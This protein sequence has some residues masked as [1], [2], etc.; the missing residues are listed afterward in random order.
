MPR[1]PQGSILLA[2]DE[3][4]LVRLISR[5]LEGAGYRVQT[6][7]TA[8]AACFA[9][10]ADEPPDVLLEPTL[11][12]VQLDLAS[13]NAALHL[14]VVVEVGRGVRLV[15]EDVEGG[16]HRRISKRLR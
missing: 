14:G 7:T 13:P 10:E 15:L 4:I 9:L 8:E 2:E 16:E 11:R 12:R 5:V 1:E 6:A 3:P